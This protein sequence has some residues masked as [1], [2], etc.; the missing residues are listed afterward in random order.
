MV[1]VCFC[2]NCITLLK[3]N[4]RAVVCLCFVKKNE[5]CVCLLCLCII[6]CPIF[7][8]IELKGIL[9]LH[10]TYLFSG[11]ERRNMVTK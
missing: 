3:S 8:L 11:F 2:M 7:L 6:I 10:K 9:V 1:Y 5:S 4:E